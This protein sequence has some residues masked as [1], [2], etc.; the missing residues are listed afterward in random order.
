MDDVDQYEAE[1]R[2]S[3]ERKRRLGA[4]L[5]FLFLLGMTLAVVAADLYAKVVMV[6]WAVEL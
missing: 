1:L 3:S 2:R 6:K 4:V 5:A